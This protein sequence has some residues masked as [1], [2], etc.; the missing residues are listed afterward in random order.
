MT[1][2]SKPHVVIPIAMWQVAVLIA[3]QSLSYGYV[4]SCLNACLVTGD[5]N[6]G[7]HCY[8]GSD[9]SCPPGTIYNDINL[10]LSK[11]HR[12]LPSLIS[13]TFKH[14]SYLHLLPFALSPS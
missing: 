4:Y 11:F 6:K 14:N 7:S 5:D 9:D 10:T 13:T 12:T 3:L 1:D 8:D 2:T